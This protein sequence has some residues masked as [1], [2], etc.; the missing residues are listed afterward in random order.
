LTDAAARS[1][2]GGE[3]NAGIL[4]YFFCDGIAL[5][6]GLGTL[7]TFG[8]TKPKSMS[9]EGVCTAGVAVVFVE[10]FLHFALGTGLG[11]DRCVQGVLLLGGRVLGLVSMLAVMV[12]F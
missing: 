9:I 11:R 3:G 6:G 4:C 12:V 8:A 1:F 5:S 10:R 7:S 2:R